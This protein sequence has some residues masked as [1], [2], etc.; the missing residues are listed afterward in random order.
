VTTT[1]KDLYFRQRQKKIQQPPI[2]KRKTIID[3]D[4]VLS[5][6]NEQPKIWISEPLTYSDKHALANGDWLTDH[7]V[8]AGQKLIKQ[9]YN[10]NPGLQSVVLAHCLAFTVMKGKEF[11]Q[12]LH[13]GNH[14]WITISTIGCQSNEVDVFDSLHP[15]L[16]DQMQ[17]QVAAL[18]LTNENSIVLR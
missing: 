14:H 5:P 1:V 7:L 11:I 8:D 3:L 13:T 6:Q 18:L 15:V 17:K 12:I 9:A 2:S 4:K 10:H 16:T